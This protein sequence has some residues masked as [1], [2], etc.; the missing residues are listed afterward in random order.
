MKKLY[1]LF[2]FIILILT[3][4]TIDQNIE[5]SFISNIYNGSTASSGSIYSYFIKDRGNIPYIRIELFET[6][7]AEIEYEVK[8]N[9]G[10]VIIENKTNNEKAYIEN[11]VITIDN[12]DSF[13][14]PGKNV[15]PLNV[16]S[17]N[18][19][20]VDV[21]G[22]EYQEGNKK[23]LN[24]S[25]Y[26]IYLYQANGACYM[27]FAIF[28]T[29]F[30]ELPFGI[31]FVFNGQDYY[32]ISTSNLFNRYGLTEYGKNYYSL[33]ND[34]EESE[35]IKKFS[36]N[37]LLFVLDNF[38][39]L[40]EEKNID[41]FTNYFEK[42]GINQDN[43]ASKL[44]ELTNYYLDDPHSS[45]NLP[46]IYD[47]YDEQAITKEKKNKLGKRSKAIEQAQDTLKILRRGHNPY[48]TALNVYNNVAYLIYDEFVYD[49]SIN[50]YEKGI[51]K[52]LS[53]SDG[54]AYISYYLNYIKQY[55]QKVDKVVID[56]SLNS[57]GYVDSAMDMLGF[58]SK[59]YSVNFINKSTNSKIKIDLNTDCNLNHDF[60]DLDSFENVF[61]FYVLVS[62]ASFSC[63][64]TFA[65]ILKNEA[66]A[67]ILGEDSAG[68]ACVVQRVTLIDGIQLNVSG[69]IAFADSDYNIIENGIKVDYKIE[70]I[71][72]YNPTYMNLYI[73]NL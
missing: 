36:Y 39:G 3:S 16:I 18:N 70:R 50:L 2:V 41:S 67:T 57:G 1:V 5:R 44:I 9:D 55:Y 34:K 32:S 27:P 20:Y 52:G 47:E 15:A 60:T 25:D 71:N 48:G 35:D 7:V 13:F 8:Y 11:N 65:S 40:K 6:I 53:S 10:N 33:L 14:K 69:P 31:N 22:Y 24:L 61:D 72:M 21:K 43:Y 38:Y 42:I 30:L 19:R 62:N 63:A 64:N 73:N 17:R 54:F 37:Q 68:G 46:S 28:E 26:D 51:N 23:V 49:S 29:I 58:I 12:Y 4:C 66:A 59:D 45:Y 56:I